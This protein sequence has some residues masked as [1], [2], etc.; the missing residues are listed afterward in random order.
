MLSNIKTYQSETA[1]QRSS[2][3]NSPLCCTPGCLLTKES[4]LIWLVAAMSVYIHAKYS[5]FTD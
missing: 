1:S 3:Q 4:L 2:S 5:G